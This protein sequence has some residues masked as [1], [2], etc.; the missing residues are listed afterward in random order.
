MSKHTLIV[1]L[2]N[3]GREYRNNRH[4]VGF[5][6]LDHLA[7]RHG[8]AFTRQQADALIATG[9][10]AG[11]AVILAKPQ[12][13]MNNS[14]GPVASLQRFY[15][16]DLPQL[17][18]VF[19]D[20]DLPPGTIRMRPSG[21]SSGQ[22]GMKSIIERLGSEGF[23]RL[24]IGIGRPPGRMDPAAYVLQDFSEEERAI[25]QEVYER[26]ADAIETWLTDGIELAM[27]RY[28]G[29]LDRPQGSA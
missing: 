24:R 28:N 15:K 18:V 26:A 22:K 9:Q 10:I 16:I 27:S 1:G 25:M 2:G 23:P 13:F 19:D 29:P 8:L 5:Q 4:N 11:R 17:L 3:P 12:T 7:E 14:G 6:V 20:L 21:G